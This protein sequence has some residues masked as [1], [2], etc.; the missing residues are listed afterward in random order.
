MVPPH[1]VKVT[2]SQVFDTHW[3]SWLPER[4]NAV[5]FQPEERYS[6]LYI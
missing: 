1:Q 4:E 3:S 6:Y 5:S 2:C